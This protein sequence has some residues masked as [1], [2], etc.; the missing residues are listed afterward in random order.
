MKEAPGGFASLAAAVRDTVLPPPHLMI[1]AEDA[2]Q[3][4]ALK[5][6]VD[7]NYRVDCYLIGP[8]DAT[9]PGVL[10]AYR[11][12]ASLTAWLCRGMQC[13]PPVHSREE[14]ET[15]LA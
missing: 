7:A 10:G 11:D 3:G 5:R 8:A 15:M 14:L 12:E 13:M 1:T 2:D 9:L 4:E 6:W